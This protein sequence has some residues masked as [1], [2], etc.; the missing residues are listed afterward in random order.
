[1]A[2]VLLFG[3]SIVLAALGLILYPIRAILSYEL[4]LGRKYMLRNLFFGV[5][6]HCPDFLPKSIKLKKKFKKSYL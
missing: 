1:M 6:N 5:L 4:L 2:S 3:A